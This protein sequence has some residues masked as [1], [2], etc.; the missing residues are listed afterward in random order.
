MLSHL[1]GIERGADALPA[2]PFEAEAA[3]QLSINRELLT[4]QGGENPYRLH[5][6]LGALMT[7]RVGVVRDNAGLDRALDELAVLEGRAAHMDLTEAS[8][9]ANQTLAYA[10]QVQ[11]MIRLGRVMAASARA[12]DECRG[13]HYKPEFDLPLPTARDPEGPDW[14]HYRERWQA[15][16]ER[17][18]K[19]T[20][21][22]HGVDGPRIELEPV[23]LSV[24][25]PNQP[26]DYR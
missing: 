8:P 22:E 19:T 25:A 24:L 12:R 11:D 6:A 16:N 26:R 15:N 17:W 2:A 23:D 18:L 4:G 13:A 5:E 7:S 3:R 20:V 1:A 9:W 21:A 10:R 14:Q